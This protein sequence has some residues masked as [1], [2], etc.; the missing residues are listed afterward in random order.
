MNNFWILKYYTAEAKKEG[1]SDIKA[2]PMEVEEGESKVKD[3]P[4][5][6]P[7]APDADKEPKEEPAA[8]A[9]QYCY[10]N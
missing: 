6:A 7:A 8:Q 1:S 2:E 10:Y 4:Q 9:G 5:E 3:E